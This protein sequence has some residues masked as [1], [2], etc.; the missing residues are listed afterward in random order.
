MIDDYR[1]RKVFVAFVKLRDE[2]KVPFLRAGIIKGLDG[3]LLFNSMQEAVDY[4]RDFVAEKGSQIY[5]AAS[6]HSP[7]PEGPSSLP[8]DQ[9][10]V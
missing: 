2:L 4:M 1:E 6:L 3:H 10:V 8:L 7:T 5:H 9:I